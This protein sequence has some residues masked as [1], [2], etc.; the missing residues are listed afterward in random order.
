MTKADYLATL[1]EIESLIGAHA[2]TPAGERL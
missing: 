1:K 2:N